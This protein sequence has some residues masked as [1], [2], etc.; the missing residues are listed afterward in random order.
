MDADRRRDEA[1]QAPEV[2]H[3]AQRPLPSRR[4]VRRSGPPPR[5]GAAVPEPRPEVG[6][7][8]RRPIGPQVAALRER[9]RRLRPQRPPGTPPP[10]TRARLR[11]VLRW[12]LVAQTVPLVL[13]AYSGSVR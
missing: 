9:L 1:S 11:R 3:P 2:L 12:A 7:P 6:R 5:R 13:E 10:S 4:G 8:S